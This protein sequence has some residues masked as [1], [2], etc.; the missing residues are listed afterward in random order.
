ME[1]AVI[2]ARYSSHS[3]TEA[4]IEKQI[5]E[6]T[7]Y[8]ESRGFDIVGE[9]VDRAKTGTN[10]DRV[11]FQKMMHDA[12]NKKF[13]AVIVFAVNRFGRDS[14]QSKLYIKELNKMG[15]TVHS[16]TESFVKSEEPTEKLMTIC[17]CLQTKER[18]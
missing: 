8:A 10:F 3:Q 1:N 2:Y 17:E 18:R 16:T 15:I 9:Y 11:E 14:L 4:T 13:V 12:K 5:E 7:K 6:C